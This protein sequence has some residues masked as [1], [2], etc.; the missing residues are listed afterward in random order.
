MLETVIYFA[1]YLKTTPKKRTGEV[2]CELSQRLFYLQ[3]AATCSTASWRLICQQKGFIVRVWRTKMHSEV[4][5]SP[6]KVY[7]SPLKIIS[8]LKTKPA[9]CDLSSKSSDQLWFVLG[10]NSFS[11]IDLI[12]WTNSYDITVTC[13][14]KNC[15]WPRGLMDKASDFGSEDW[16]F[17][18]LCGRFLL[19]YVFLSLMT[20]LS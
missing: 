7:Q 4:R 11:W 20:N 8:V 10:N 6:K 5:K 18:S 19:Y 2:S 14:C 15:I 17:E 12:W 16:G 3:D 13:W 1:Y 9:S